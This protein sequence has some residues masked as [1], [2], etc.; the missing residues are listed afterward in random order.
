MKQVLRADF[1]NCM[2]WKVC[3]NGD[4]AIPSTSGILDENLNCLKISGFNHVCFYSGRKNITILW[5]CHLS[6]STAEW[7]MVGIVS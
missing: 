7:S 5:Y 2:R 6:L 4:D 3:E 1:I